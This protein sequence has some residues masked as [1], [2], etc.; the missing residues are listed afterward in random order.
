MCLFTIKFCEFPSNIHS[1]Y[2]EKDT[3]INISISDSKLI[4][5]WAWFIGEKE[6]ERSLNSRDKR[7]FFNKQSKLKF[8][9]NCNI[10]IVVGKFC[11]VAI[12]LL[13]FVPLLVS[14]LPILFQGSRNH[15]DNGIFLIIHVVLYS[16][17]YNRSLDR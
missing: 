3:I 11:V 7:D 15:H 9:L 6:T 4:E 1:S 5:Y 10:I 17:N 8:L 2:H 16:F 12:G 14:F 13:I